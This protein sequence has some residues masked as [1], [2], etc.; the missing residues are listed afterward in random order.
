MNRYITLLTIGL[1]AYLLSACQ[2]NPITN[3]P[4]ASNKEV[5][6]GAVAGAIVGAIGFE[7]VKLSPTSGVLLGGLLGGHLATRHEWM[8]DNLRK[9]GITVFEQGEILQVVL[10][11]DRLFYP[12]EIELNMSSHGVLNHVLVMLA[13]FS[14]QPI[15]IEGHTDDHQDDIDGIYLSEAKARAVAT[16]LWAH[17]ISPHRVHITGHGQFRTTADLASASGRADNR[18]VI[19]STHRDPPRFDLPWDVP[20]IY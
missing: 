11:A 18:A 7:A 10:P 9:Q 20:L 12:G 5:V 14:R 17:G 15:F 4:P 13:R 6:Q 19:I 2:I 8:I 16:Y 3:R 1:S